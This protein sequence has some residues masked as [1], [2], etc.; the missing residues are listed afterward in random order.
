MNT[1]KDGSAG[2]CHG[3]T[4]TGDVTGT[5]DGPRHFDQ[6]PESWLIGEALARLNGD[7]REAEGGYQRAT[8]L[9]VKIG[10]AEAFGRI[11]AS[12]PRGDVPLRWSLLHVLA[13]TADPR[14]ADL[15]ARAAIEPIRMDRD[16]RACETAYDGEVLVRTMAIEGL[17]RLAQRDASLVGHL[18]KVLEA[19]GD[20]ALKIE[21]VKAIRAAAPNEAEKLREHLPED[22][23]FAV[24]L[25]QV[26]AQSLGVEYAATAVDSVRAMPG[27][28]GKSATPAARPRCCC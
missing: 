20:R 3:G 14:A 6:D 25:K 1:A 23:R 2:N 22:L 24:D 26:A 19:Q 8:E 13:D 21:A 28:D 17:G 11:L 15:F 4:I 12:V 10:A 27:L 7:S 9:L 18:W 5:E 16:P